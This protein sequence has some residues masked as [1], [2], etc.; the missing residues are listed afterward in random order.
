MSKSVDRPRTAP[1]TISVSLRGGFETD[2]HARQFGELIA[3][4]VGEFSRYMELGTLDGVTI[5]ANYGQALLDLDLGYAASQRLKAS[6]KLAVGIAMT[7]SVLRD[8]QLK[9]HMVFDAAAIIGLEDLSNPLYGRAFHL[10]AHE[11]AHV[12]VTARFDAAFPGMILRKRPANLHD[13]HRWEVIGVCWDEY[14]VTQIC[15]NYGQPSTDAYEEI[16]L[17]A[18]NVTRSRANAFIR[19]YRLHGKLNQVLAEVYGCYGE[20]MKFSCYF[21]GDLAGRSLTLHDRPAAKS[22]LDR[23]WFAPHFEKLH[24]IC[25]SIALEYGRWRDLSVFE[26]LGDLVDEVVSYGGL[27]IQ[28]KQTDGRFDVDIPLTSETTPD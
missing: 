8:G 14:A 5:A 12:E 10:L 22:A 16:F 21:L 18:L 24:V 23:S 13:H 1:A 25:E 3:A 7:P 26:A 19:Q 15:A 17:E 4:Y 2:E 20:L 28:N 9:S 6:D 27:Y 11:C